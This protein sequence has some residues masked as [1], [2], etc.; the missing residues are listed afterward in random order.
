MYSALCGW[1]FSFDFETNEIEG[2]EIDQNARIINEA[3]ANYC[4]YAIYGLI[5]HLTSTSNLTEQQIQILWDIRLR[6]L[7][8]RILTNYLFD[9]NAYELKS[10]LD[11]VDIEMQLLSFYPI[12]LKAL[13]G[14]TLQQ[15]TNTIITQF[16]KHE[17][18]DL[19][20]Q[21]LA[22]KSEGGIG[23]LIKKR[24]GWG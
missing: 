2:K 11:I 10:E 7:E 1:R 13:K 14:F 24:L 20:Q 12:T 22:P 6:S 21:T 19:S 15:I 5:S 16:L 17:N 9:D 23:S 3:G 8:R 4:T 18:N